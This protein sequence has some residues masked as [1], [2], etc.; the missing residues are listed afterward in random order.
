MQQEYVDVLVIGAGPSGCVSSSIIHNSGLKTMV[1]EKEKFPRFVIGES[2]LPRCMVA[3]TEAGLIDTI[4]EQKFQEKFGAKFLQQDK[5]CEFT[6]ADQ[7]TEGW[8]WTWQVPRADFDTAMSAKLMEKGIP[9][10]F[11]TAVTA[12]EFKGTDSI[13]TVRDKEGNERQIH[14]KFVIDSSGYGRALP[15]LLDL[16][17]PSTFPA[18][19]TLFAHFKD[20]NRPDTHNNSQI[21]VIDHKPEVWIW[22]IP[23][24]NGNVSCGFVGKPEFFDQYT[25]TDE[26]KLRAMISNEPNIIE[27][28]GTAPMVWDEPKTIEGYA[29]ATKKHYGDGFV[30]TGN[31][32]EFLDPVFSS[33]VTFAVE[34]GM[35]AAKLAS[36]QV[37]GENVDWEKEYKNYIMEGVDVFRTYVRAWYEGKLQDIFFNPQ[38]DENIKKMIC[39]VLAGYVWDKENYYVKNHARAIDTL[40]QV[41]RMNKQAVA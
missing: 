1:V 8:N 2:L 5:V 22:V 9:V 7:Y 31:A 41:V 35:V 24:S 23:F 28:M 11:E 39:S 32:A 16:D 40:A 21:I 6:F 10:H 14:A 36:R 29:I 38:I 15:R 13:T 25:G 37:K 33:G 30:L 3:L 20:I 27:R 17:K 18:R 34:S 26:E 12:I 4:K 19:K